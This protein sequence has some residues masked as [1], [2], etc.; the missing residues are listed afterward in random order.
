M[1]K[2]QKPAKM[3]FNC[4]TKK[5]EFLQQQQQNIKQYDCKMVQLA[6]DLFGTWNVLSSIV[7]FYLS[8]F[9]LKANV[10]FPFLV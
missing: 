2:S 3:C 4:V 7:K 10:F 6:Y 9:C 1:K 8:H 5:N